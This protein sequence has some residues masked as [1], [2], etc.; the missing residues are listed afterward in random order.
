MHCLC[1]QT[2]PELISEHVKV[3]KFP[4]EHASGTHHH[5]LRVHL[6]VT[7]HLQSQL[8]HM[9]IS[10]THTCQDETATKQ[11]I[12]EPQVPSLLRLIMRQRIPLPNKW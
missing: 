7:P 1:C 4:R 6:G 8:T 12:K 5:L 11:F 2:A 10:M 3:Q 9:I